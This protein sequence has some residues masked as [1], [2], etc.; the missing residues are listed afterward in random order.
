MKRTRTRPTPIS[1]DEAHAQARK[2]GYVITLTERG[3]GW[4]ASC[5]EPRF[6]PIY[7]TIPSPPLGVGK[8]AGEA[9]ADAHRKASEFYNTMI[10]KWTAA[11]WTRLRRLWDYHKRRFPEDVIPDLKAPKPKVRRRTRAA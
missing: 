11:D 6:T 4:N 5:S 10:G 7:S 8:T 9:I 2:S 3:S 1:F